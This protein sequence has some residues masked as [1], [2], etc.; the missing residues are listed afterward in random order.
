MLC[1]ELIAVC[2]EIHKK[3]NTIWEKNVEFSNLKRNGT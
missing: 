1:R 2:S 3:E